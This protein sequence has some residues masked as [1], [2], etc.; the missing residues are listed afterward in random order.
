MFNN[1]NRSIL[2]NLSL[3]IDQKMSRHSF[4]VIVCNIAQY[5]Q[6]VILNAVHNLI[7]HDVAYI[8]APLNTKHL[9]KLN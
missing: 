8:V 2:I 7:R 1:L 9:I 6:N 3:S 4:Y 5:E